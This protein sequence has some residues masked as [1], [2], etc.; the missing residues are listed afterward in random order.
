MSSAVTP[1]DPAPGIGPP[2]LGPVVSHRT[3]ER[4]WLVV[5]GAML[6][7]AGIFFGWR[8]LFM[9]AM[10]AV[11]AVASFAL[12]YVVMR[13]VRR[14]NGA[15]EN[16]EAT[17]TY[18]VHLGL[19]M[20][21]TLPLMPQMWHSVFA[22]I[23]VGVL[24]HVM[25]PDRQLRIHPVAV[26][27]VVLLVAIP[28][29]GL[30][31]NDA[32]LAPSHIVLG[33]V[34]R[35]GEPVGGPTWLQTRPAPD[36]HALRREPPGR[37][38]L[39]EQDKVLEHGSRIIMLLKDGDLPRLLD[40]IIGAVPG[41]VGGTSAGLIILLGMYLIY[42]RLGRWPMALWA[43]AAAIVTLCLLPIHRPH[44]WTLSLVAF[45]DVGWRVAVA[46]LSYQLLAT[47]L[48]LIVLVLA[49]L[50]MPRTIQGRML[51]GLLVGSMVIAFRWIAPY[52]SIAYLALV[53]AGVLCPVL[54]RLHTSPFANPRTA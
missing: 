25:G 27:H 1:I 30:R 42:R 19:M 34:T 41:P 8:A 53:A 48:L 5:S 17:L 28:L 51:F 13:L 38:M 2:W 36:A 44:G 43:I 39:E 21:L 47:P 37:L 11:L 4:Q 54:D 14:D 29:T 10:T 31:G 50:A 33:D 46:Y 23:L 32:V 22:G 52:E 40:V 6:A 45:S 16:P 20:G 9:V 7:S 26:V 3:Y 49:P 24:A 35:A 12:G 15:N 18:A